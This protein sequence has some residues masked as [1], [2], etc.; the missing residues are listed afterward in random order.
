VD[1]KRRIN[2]A[3]DRGLDAFEEQERLANIAIIRTSE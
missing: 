2:V 3:E 1:H